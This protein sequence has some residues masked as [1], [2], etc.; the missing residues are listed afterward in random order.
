[1]DRP[2]DRLIF[3]FFYRP[4]RLPFDHCRLCHDMR[5]LRDFSTDDLQQHIHCLLAGP[6]DIGIHGSN[7]PIDSLEKI[8]LSYPTT[9]TSSGTRIPAFCRVLITPSAISSFIAQ[10]AVKSTPPANQLLHVTNAAWSPVDIFAFDQ[11]FGK[12]RNSP[13]PRAHGCIASRRSEVVR[14]VLLPPINTMF[15]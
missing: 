2:F 3:C 1:M 11:I 9:D 8:V 14:N 13:S 6:F 4:A 7:P 5:F 15:R 12:D 10:I